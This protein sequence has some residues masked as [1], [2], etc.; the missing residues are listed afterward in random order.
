MSFGAEASPTAS[1]QPSPAPQPGDGS[2]GSDSGGDSTS[3]A[4][5]V[6][7]AVI[8]P[9]VALAALGLLAFFLL[10]SRR[11]RWATHSPAGSFSGSRDMLSVPLAG[12]AAGGGSR[13]GSL[14]VSERSG[15]DILIEI[16]A[17]A[18]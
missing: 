5:V 8:V 13:G 18:R 12:A 11:R 17:D 2:N 16:P 3:V 4:K 6:A 14:T 1:P 9:V 10:S 7:P 15:S